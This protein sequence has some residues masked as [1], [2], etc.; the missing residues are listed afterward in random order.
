MM[1]PAALSGWGGYPRAQARVLAPRDL[2]TLRGLEGPV[3][4]RGQGR[5][6]GDA[7]ISSGVTLDMRHFDRLIAFDPATGEL[8]A[9]AGVTLAEIIRLFLP[10]GFFPM[11][12]PGTRFVS[13]GGAFAADVHGKNHHREGSFADHVRAVQILDARGD[14][15]WHDADSET[16]AQA[17]GAMG[18]T[19]IL[20]ALRLRLRPVQSGWIAQRTHVAGDLETALALF[21]THA[22]ARYSVGWMDCTA[23][24]AALGRGLV[25]TG[26]HCDAPVGRPR[27]P[28]ARRGP[29]IPVHMP[30]GLLNP[31]TLRAFNALY[32]ARGTRVAAQAGGQ[33]VDWQSFFYPLDG[34]RNW[35]RLY[36]RAGFVQ[37]QCVLPMDSAHAGLRM[38]LRM[39]A[40]TGHGSPLAVLKCMGPQAGRWSFPMPGMTLALDFPC[41]PDTLA[42]IERLDAV[43]V[44][45]GGRF[46][47]AKDARLSPAVFAASDPRWADLHAARHVSGA[48]ARFQS[49][50]S[51]RLGL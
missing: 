43:T 33:V 46:Y 13:L 3:I 31:L 12:T 44:D 14:V 50:Q 1:Q 8:T 22:E 29:A 5:A 10:R 28:A 36:G 20:V 40:Q 37:F 9:E 41:R 45:H 34:L 27:W 39:I 47:L 32:F 11:V 15:A 38:I 42:L 16:F 23:A 6:Y 25:M 21:E 48:A 30:R 7:A 35:P 19:G 51:Q 24:G 49:L 4:A 18:L 17:R 26:D 2:E